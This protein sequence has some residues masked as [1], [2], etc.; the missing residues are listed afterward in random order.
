MT[1]NIGRFI[2]AIILLP[3][4][5]IAQPAAAVQLWGI[6]YTVSKKEQTYYNQTPKAAAGADGSVWVTWSGRKDA[7]APWGVYMS[8]WEDESWSPP[9]MLSD[10]KEAARAPSISIGPQGAAWVAWHA[11]TGSD[12]KIRVARV[13]K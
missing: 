11:G 3:A 6:P 4:I 7:D 5:L 2:L 8:R 1:D 10:G 13:K 12:M 9:R